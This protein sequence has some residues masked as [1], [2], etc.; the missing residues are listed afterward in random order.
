VNLIGVALALAAAIVWGG[1]DFSGG[2]ASRRISAFQ[3]LALSAASGLLLL[4]VFALARGEPMPQREAAVF[5]LAAGVAGS[6][7]LA[8]LYRG[9]S[10]GSA[11]LVAPTSGVIGAA[12]PVVFT[13]LVVGAP[14][15]LQLAGF[16]LALAGI[17]L[18]ARSPA[19]EVER[20]SRQ[21]FLLAVVA[22]LGFG[23]FFILIARAGAELVF[24]PLILARGTEFAVALLLMAVARQG[25]PSVRGNPIALL[26]GLLDAGGNM[27]YVLAGQFVRLDVAAVIASLYPASTVV[28]S[29]IIL[30]ERVGAGQKI[31]VVLC[32]AA[33][34]LITL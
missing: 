32:L 15:P 30:R 21:G 8:A 18:V 22:G 2:L 28:L 19:H 33:I 24:T 27:L 17:F 12:A 5:A 34:L 11:A 10:V 29:S 31:G 20:D 25:V 1:G 16:A 4:V 3:V 7:G 14:A 6:I 23:A 9:L 13:A 26:A